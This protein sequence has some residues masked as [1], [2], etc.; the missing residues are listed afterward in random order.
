MEKKSSL[1]TLL[2]ALALLL[3][4]SA[5]FAMFGQIVSYGGT[6]F[7]T[8]FQ[9]A[10]GDFD[11]QRITG[12][13]WIFGLQMTILALIAT[14][15]VGMLTRK[16]HYIVTI[17]LYALACLFSFIVLI[18]SFNALSLYS[19]AHPGGYTHDFSLGAGPI[20][21]S[22]LHILGLVST[23]AGLVFSRLKA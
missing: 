18:V 13:T 7:P 6:R 21:F 3:F 17:V 1:S 12:M 9:S 16:I 4:V 15:I 14:I 5:T 19:A 10:F 23:V 8:M 20:A 2:F 22:I 11:G